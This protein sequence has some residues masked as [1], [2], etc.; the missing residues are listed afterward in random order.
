MSGTI[1]APIAREKTR[2][3]RVLGSLFTGVPIFV[4]PY[5]NNLRD[6][7]ACEFL[8]DIGP[9]MA[10]NVDMLGAILQRMIMDEVES[11][12]ALLAAVTSADERAIAGS[13]ASPAT[14]ATC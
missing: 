12:L 6:P 10:P 3:K 7:P 14:H 2:W 8:Q 9:A 4:V 11:G 13:S 1:T 5:G